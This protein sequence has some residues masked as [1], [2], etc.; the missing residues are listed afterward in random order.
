MSSL[1]DETKTVTK[2][3]NEANSEETPIIP[4][5]DIKIEKND[6]MLVFTAADKI[7]AYQRWEVEKNQLT[8]EA[9]TIH[10]LIQ[11]ANAKLKLIKER[12]IIFETKRK[13]LR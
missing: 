10:R 11:A 3:N 6:Q 4:A 12:Q 13:V 2:T 9:L 1:I 7:V 8:T 5:K